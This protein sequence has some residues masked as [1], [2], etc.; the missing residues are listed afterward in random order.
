MKNSDFEELGEMLAR[1]MN[2]KANIVP[3]VDEGDE[4]VLLND[5]SIENEMAVLPV[6]DQ[7]LFPGVMIPIA[8]RRPKSRRLLD[9]VNGTPQ[10]ILVFPQ[11]NDSE[12]PTELDLYPV[13]VVARV[14]R[15]FTFKPDI[16]V[17]VLQGVTRCH[18]LV[19]TARDP[20]MRG[21]VTMAPESTAA[22]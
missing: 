15:V 4:D 22:A 18:S 8:A 17:A 14:L 21:T 10:H 11:R 20:Y 3:M 2:V 12:D 9:E 7:V 16:S 19:V 6:M 1:G 5:D 13:G